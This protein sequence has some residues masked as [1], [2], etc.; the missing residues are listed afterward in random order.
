[1]FD[2]LLQSI[3]QT[4][5]L[6]N[7]FAIFVG[8]VIGVVIGAIPGMTVV[9]AVALALPFTFNLEPITGLLLLLGIYKG[10]TY[11]GSIT[12]ITIRTP[13]TSAAACT[14]LD[15]F[16][17]TQKGQ[18]RK[19]LD[20]SLYSS[21]TADIISN[22]ALI[23]GASWLASFAL[24]FGSAEYFAL[25]AFSLTIIASISGVYVI[26]GIISAFLGLFL[27]TV[28]L[29]LFYGFPRMTMGIT[30]LFS[31]ISFVT[32]LIGI[33]AIP[34]IF[35]HCVRPASEEITNTE[36][37]TVQGKA[38]TFKEFWEHKKTIIRGS[39]IGVIIGAI[40][41]LGST[42]A[43]F[44]SY[45]EA[46]RTSKTP[47]E[48]GKGSLDGVAAAEAGNNGVAGSTL[49][50]LL[51]LG[52]PGDVVTAILLGAFMVH[53]IKPGPLLFTENPVIVYS[54]FLG[55]LLSSPFMFAVG[56]VAI[57][58]FSKVNKIPKSLLFSIVLAFCMYGS[59][60]LNNSLFDIYIML[61]MGVL[62]FLMQTVKV[63]PA[64][65]VIGFVLGNMF[66]N[67][68]RQSL[69]TSAGSLSIFVSSPISILFWIL[70][71]VSIIFTIKNYK[72]L[73]KMV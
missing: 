11:G 35:N 63:P 32:L 73:S 3:A 66:E 33:F 14:I 17:L 54:L 23:F 55:I 31:G 24:D 22:L 13:G 15:G 27:A 70:T 53:D 57:R 67:S 1:M 45:S 28:G 50:P 52:V 29:D 30:D 8:V 9:M 26:N 36:E 72:Q 2:I 21:I 58:V 39:F 46:K 60:A 10:G 59:F 37:G 38:L 19:A 20:M 65:F 6:I 16:P 61:A 7:C 48:F 5:T 69:V 62:G 68:F 56:K 64:P 47:E 18:A 49:V 4:F 40:P 25:T 34:E 41:G 51:S 71:L 42:P 43:A 12:A 44:L